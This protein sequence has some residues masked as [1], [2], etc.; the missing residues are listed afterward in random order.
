M[1]V[2]MFCGCVHVCFL[3]VSVFLGMCV[4][5]A[6]TD[7]ECLPYFL[8]PCSFETGSHTEPGAHEFLVASE[9]QGFTCLCLP[10]TWILST[11]CSAKC[12]CTCMHVHVCVV[13]RTL[14]DE[15]QGLMLLP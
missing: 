2:C 10:R 9:M 13:G 11:C 3:C 8:P 15:T 14:R 1:C 7:S 5:G 4:E 6:E 12:V